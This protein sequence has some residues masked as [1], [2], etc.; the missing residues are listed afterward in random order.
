MSQMIEF[1][2]LNNVFFICLEN[3]KMYFLKVHGNWNI[4]FPVTDGII[5]NKTERISFSP[6][7]RVEALDK[8]DWPEHGITEEMINQFLEGVHNVAN[9]TA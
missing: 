8:D 7:K 9:K 3:K 5:A 4:P 6:N 1:H 2:K